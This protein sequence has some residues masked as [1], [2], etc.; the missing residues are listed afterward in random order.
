MARTGYLLEAGRTLAAL[1][2]T[3]SPLY[4]LPPTDWTLLSGVQTMLFS[5]SRGMELLGRPGIASVELF[6]PDLQQRLG[7]ANISQLQP[8]APT[9]PFFSKILMEL[10][11]AIGGLLEALSRM[12][13]S[14]T[15]AVFLERRYLREAPTLRCMRSS[16]FL[17]SV[18][19]EGIY[20]WKWHIPLKLGFQSPFFCRYM[21]RCFDSIAPYGMLP[22]WVIAD[23]KRNSGIW[24]Q[25]TR[26]PQPYST[27]QSYRSYLQTKFEE[28]S[29][30]S[31]LALSL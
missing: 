18:V 28:N 29:S 30:L 19:L 6:C 5:K 1:F 4:P 12:R 16:S 23:H 31:L 20:E 9:M 8:R 2:L 10:L 24:D 3:T 21:M 15:L 14:S 25:P 11:G 27:I 7:V 26:C 13:L 17:R 22:A